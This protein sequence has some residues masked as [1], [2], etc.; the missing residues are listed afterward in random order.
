[1]QG[2]QLPAWLSVAGVSWASAGG[3]AAGLGP[4][5]PLVVLREPGGPRGRASGSS[6]PGGPRP[7]S[8]RA[9]KRRRA[10]RGGLES[11]SPNEDSEAERRFLQGREIGVKA[12]EPPTLL[13]RNLSIQIPSH[14]PC[15]ATVLIDQIPKAF[16]GDSKQLRSLGSQSSQF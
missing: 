10:P 8:S 1:M 2:G 14:P 4:G 6:G 9:E 13:A 5:L 15:P 3:E 11:L 16:P 7:G 12:E